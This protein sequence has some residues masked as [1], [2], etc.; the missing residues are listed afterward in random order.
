MYKRQIRYIMGQESLDTFD[1]YVENIKKLG[2]DRAI[3]IQNAALKRY[4]ER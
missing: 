2:I 1:K 3:E 4:N